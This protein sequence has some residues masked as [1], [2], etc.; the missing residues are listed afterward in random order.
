[1]VT[2]RMLPMYLQFES[3]ISQVVWIVVYVVELLE[4]TSAES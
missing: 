2:Y 1:M 3:E 4:Q